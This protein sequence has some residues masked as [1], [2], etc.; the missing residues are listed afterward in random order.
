MKQKETINGIEIVNT[1]N[2]DIIRKENIN[3]VPVQNIFKRDKIRINRNSFQNLIY[4]KNITQIKSK[5]NLCQKNKE[6]Y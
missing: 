5:K 4:K 6:Q 3:E 2:S 1:L